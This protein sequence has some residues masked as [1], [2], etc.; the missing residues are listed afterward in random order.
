MSHPT[1]IGLP[2]DTTHNAPPDADNIDQYPE[3]LVRYFL[4]H[5]T[6]AGDRILDPFIGFGTTA[7]VAEDMNRTPYG[8]EADGERFEWAAGQIAHWQ[9][10]KHGDAADIPEHNFP[11]MDFCITSP[12]Y[13]PIS[14]KW[15]PLYGGD[16]DHAGYETYLNRLGFIFD[17]IA[18][19]MKK[20]AHIIVQA[21]NLQGKPYTP[22][23]RDFSTKISR[24]LKPQGEVIIRW[25]GEMPATLKEYTH[26]HCLIFKK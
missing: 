23:V 15:N 7:F 10:I 19:V 11:K 13:M 26:T 8:I 6:K 17:R 1:F 22:L 4:E 14:D 5:Y 2:F 18:E 9:N 25:S 12:P 21:D 16:P 20:N 24:S 3:S